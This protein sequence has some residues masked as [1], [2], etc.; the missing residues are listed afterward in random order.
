MFKRYITCGLTALAAVAVLV[1]CNHTEMDEVVAGVPT[2]TLRISTGMPT[3]AAA[4]TDPYGE[5]EKKLNTVDLFFYQTGS[6]G[7]ALFAWHGTNAEDNKELKVSIPLEFVDPSLG[8]TDM[9]FDAQHHCDVYAVVNS[10]EA[11]E[12]EKLPTKADLEALKVTTAFFADK[13]RFDS[14]AGL[15]MFTEKTPTHKAENDDTVAPNVVTLDPATN[16][17]SGHIYVNTPAAKIDLFVGFADSVTGPDPSEVGSSVPYE[18]QVEMDDEVPALAEVHIFNG[19]KSVIL[20]APGTGIEETDY[21][22]TRDIQTDEHML[23][24][25]LVK[26]AEGDREKY[27]YVTEASFYTYPN[28]WEP[29]SSLLETHRTELR[30]KVQWR[31]YEGGSPTQDEAVDTYYM[32]P[33]NLDGMKIE[34]NKYYRLKVTINTL[35]GAN[36]GAPV[37]LEGT[38]EVMDWGTSELEADIREFHYLDVQQEVQDREDGQIYKAI[39]EGTTSVTIP[40]S[41]SSKIKIKGNVTIEYLDLSVEYGRGNG[42]GSDKN[43]QVWG[44]GKPVSDILSGSK[45]ELK[46]DELQS[47]NY[48]GVYI[49]QINKTLTVYHDK[50][51]TIETDTKCVVDRSQGVKFDYVPY[52][53]TFTIGHDETNPKVEDK[54][55][56]IKH[57]PPIWVSGRVNTSFNI[58]GYHGTSLTKHIDKF[59]Y[60]NSG[61]TLYV[62]GFVRINGKDYDDNHLGGV[63]RTDKKDVTYNDPATNPI[64]YVVTTTQLPENSKYH[65]ADPRQNNR[66]LDLSNASMFDMPQTTSD[67]GWN[68]G[69][70]FNNGVYTPNAGH[71]LTYYYPTNESMAQE[72][73]WA[74]SPQYRV[75]STFGTSEGEVDRET[76]RRRCAAYQEYGYPAGRWRLPTLGE[77][78]FIAYLSNETVIP[79]LFGGTRGLIN[80]KEYTLPYWCAQGVY[81]YKS[82]SFQLVNGTTGYV[83]CVYDEWYWVR[84]DGQPDNIFVEASTSANNYQP[85]TKNLYDSNRNLNGNRNDHAIF[86]WG[87]REKNN[88]QQQ[89]LST[90]MEP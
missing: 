18:W 21:F 50:G 64:M 72:D 52:V 74:L 8:G 85:D 89:T 70:Y 15:V 23:Y 17:A 69:D 57:Y 16:Q 73:M 19:V 9:L 24:R 47:G 41:S 62:Y 48:Q 59:D 12:L 86:V 65:I 51:K 49:D 90:E 44:A 66:N 75:A 77:M 6:T 35:G 84:E 46:A 33:L 79:P 32:V 40:F 13:K 80:P 53:I 5:D 28:S 78:D 76:A 2:V 27:P 11:G 87:D 10:K 81:Q 71:K 31:R 43:A 60:H 45:F 67:F 34:P 63:K 29:A 36:F 30:L 39:M 88:P 82:G 42:S 1:S 20:G 4:G 14:T 56:T 26:S 37:E 68:S 54:V 25:S 61:V 58:T 7:P 22:N 38:L 83:R 55:I 3:R